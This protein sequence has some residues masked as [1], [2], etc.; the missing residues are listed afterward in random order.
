MLKIDKIYLI[1]LKRSADRLE[2]FM[3]QVSKHHLPKD[4]LEIFTAIDGK[5]HQFTDKENEIL[6][7]MNES[8]SLKCNLLSHY[9]VLQDI[10]TKGYKNCLVLQDDVYFVNGFVNKIDQVIDHIPED[11][12]FINIGLHK[13]AVYEYFEDFP[14]NDV[15]DRYYC[16]E[17][18]NEYIC[19][20]K[21]DINP[22][23]LSYIVKD[24]SVFLSM[25]YRQAMDKNLNEYLI[26]KNIFYGSN[27]V[28]ATGNSNFKST[29]FDDTFKNILSTLLS[30]YSN[31]KI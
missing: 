12:E 19:K 30:S 24:C 26:S 9:Y 20:Y 10:F 8:N 16:K 11:A 29:I 18:V 3:D 17:K 1:N 2:H 28:L 14:I 13:K 7:H 4:K 15:Y 23:T 25:E 21:D 5:T 6:S 31:I 27:D 22:A